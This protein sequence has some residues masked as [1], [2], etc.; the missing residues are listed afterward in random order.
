MCSSGRCLPYGDGITFWPLVRIVGAL[1]GD[2]GVR[3]VLAGADD[4]DLI[5]DRVLGAVGP[6]PTVAPGGE[7]FWAVRR[8]FEELA[9]KQ[10]LLI[11]VE[12]IHWA[13][14]KLLDLLEYLAGWTDDA[15]ILLLCLARPELLDERPGWLSSQEA[16]SLVLGPL[17][18]AESEALLEEIGREWPLDADCAGSDHRGRRGEPS[19]RRADGGDARRRQDA[20]RDPAHDPRVAGGTAR[21]PP[22]GRAQRA[23]ARSGRG[24]GLHA[25]R[26]PPPLGRA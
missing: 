3:E 25:E 26:R 11:V 19:L 9:R 1:G 4:A 16:T 20:R 2:D 23:R 5:A 24:E 8:L 15:P 7:M 6:T 14:P 13:E 10:P 18:D 12:D 17:T 22:A 21:P